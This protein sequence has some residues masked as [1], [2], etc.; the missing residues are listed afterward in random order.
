MS[1]TT[2]LRRRK[3]AT[4]ENAKR[5]EVPPTS[6]LRNDTVVWGKTPSGEGKHCYNEFECPGLTTSS[7]PSPDHP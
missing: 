7:F 3:D 4:T 5:V 2:F 6:P 1:S